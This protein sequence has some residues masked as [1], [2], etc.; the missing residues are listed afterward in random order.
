MGWLCRCPGIV[1]ESIQKQAHTELVGKHSVTAISAS[2][3]IV[4]WISVH[5]LISALNKITTKKVQAGNEWSFSQNPCKWKKTK[6]HHYK[7]QTKSMIKIFEEWKR[8]SMPEHA[9]ISILKFW[10]VVSECSCQSKMGGE[11]ACMSVSV[12]NLLR[13]LYLDGTSVSSACYLQKLRN[14]IL[15]HAHV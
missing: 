11:C 13:M 14:S 5:K 2:W 8:E 3:A 12:W 10:K 4:D 6:K 7:S 1:L 15:L 9:Q